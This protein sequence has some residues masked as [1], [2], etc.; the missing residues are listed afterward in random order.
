MLKHLKL[1]GKK[2][3]AAVFVPYLT[4]VATWIDETQKFAPELNCCPLLG[5][6]AENY[7]LIQSSNADLFPIA[8]Q[9]AVALVTSKIKKTDES[10]GK[11]LLDP[12]KVADCFGNCNVLICDEIH[13]CF[14]AGTKISTPTGGVPIE[15]IKVG[16][17]VETSL[18]SQR[19]SRTFT[20]YTSLIVRLVLSDGRV[21][22]CTPEHPI[23]TGMGWV[24]A[25]HTQGENV[26]DYQTLSDLR[27]RVQSQALQRTNEKK[28]LWPK[29]FSEMED[30]STRNK[31]ESLFTRSKGKVQCW[32]KRILCLRGEQKD[33]SGQQQKN[34]RKK[35]I[36]NAW[37]DRKNNED[38]ERKW[39][40]LGHSTF[41]LGRPRRCRQNKF[42]GYV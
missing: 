23:L 35:S 18:G 20:D 29:L 34:D 9:S 31:G 2:P 8:Y 14:I 13:R 36:P 37:G 21:I 19:V 22:Y 6:S 42:R 41:F 11:W 28:I 5:S 16:D 10:K 39:D 24:E 38:K 17:L 33:Q 4:A 1:Q 12:E 32:F 30:V 25:Q 40:I 7:D 15:D 26:Y 27:G 3:K